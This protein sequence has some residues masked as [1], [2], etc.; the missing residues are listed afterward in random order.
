M[1]LLSF[2]SFSL[3]FP[4]HLMFSNPPGFSLRLRIYSFFTPLI[5]QIRCVTASRTKPAS[6]FSYSLLIFT[7]K[8]PCTGRSSSC[9]A[10]C[11]HCS[12]AQLLQ[13]RWSTGCSGTDDLSVPQP[14]VELSVCTIN[15]VV[16]SLLLADSSRRYLALCYS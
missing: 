14:S 6:K 16:N 15:S 7:L 3:I 4:L 13:T 1:L 8:L 11:L 2:I 9:C 5:H 12:P 10:L